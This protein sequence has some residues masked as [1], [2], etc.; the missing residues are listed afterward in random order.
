MMKKQASQQKEIQKFQN[1]KSKLLKE[2]NW[3]KD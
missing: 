3:M 2:I 1:E